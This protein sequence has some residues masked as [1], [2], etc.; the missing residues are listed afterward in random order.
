MTECSCPKGR[1]LSMPHLEGCP[2]KNP[3]DR[4]PDNVLVFRNPLGQPTSVPA[5]VVQVVDRAYAA[6]QRH[7]NG[8]TW[9]SI[10]RSDG[11]WPSGAAAAAEVKRYLAEGRSALASFQRA[12]ISRVW[13]DRL[14]MLWAAVLADAIE[15][16]VPSVM[17]ALSVAK[18]AMTLSGL[19][20]PR[21]EDATVQTVVV[22]SEEFIASLKRASGES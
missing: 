9:E 22:P 1:P 18:T 14:E 19:D 3:E 5:D 15:G 20:K 17:A 8:E 13:T 2:M 11:G 10:A 16:K 7:L 12:E 21:E 4:E 6:Y